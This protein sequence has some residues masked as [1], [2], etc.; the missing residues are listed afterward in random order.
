VVIAIALPGAPSDW[1]RVAVIVV[2]SIGLY[3]P[4]LRSLAPD[5]WAEGV[6]R[7]REVRTRHR[8][9]ARS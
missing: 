2:I 6:Q 4:L 5:V 7:Y 9:R 1:A 8:I 3:F